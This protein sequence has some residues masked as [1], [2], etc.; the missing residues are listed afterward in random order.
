M[1]QPAELGTSAY[2]NP[3]ISDLPIPGIRSVPDCECTTSSL[4][5]RDFLRQPLVGTVAFVV[6][7]VASKD[8]SEMPFVHN[9]EVVETLRPD[10]AHEPLGKSIGIRRPKGRSNDLSAL[11]RKDLVE[12]R[13]VL[14]VTIANQEFRGDVGDDEITGDVPCLLG[15]PCRVWMS[16]NTGDPDSPPAESRPDPELQAVVLGGSGTGPLG[17]NLHR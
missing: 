12:T 7:G 13:H 9:Q 11:G 17:A 5:Y 1:D 8:P 3:M 4:G 16:G 15:H 2:Q 14:C 10:R 6:T